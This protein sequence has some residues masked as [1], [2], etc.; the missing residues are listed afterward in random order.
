MKEILKKI[1]GF[2]NSKIFGYILIVIAIIFIFNL[3]GSKQNLKDEINRTNRNIEVLNATVKNE[4]LK[5]GEM[6]SSIA[7]YEGHAKEL[8]QYNK[9]L[10]DEVKSEKGKVVTYSNLVFRL[11]QDSTDLA[12]KLDS[13]RAVYEKPVKVNDST[14]NVDW[15]LPFVYD[16]VN[17]DIFTGRTQVSLGGGVPEAYLD[18][19][20]MHHN[21]TWLLNRD[22]QMKLTWGQKYEGDKLKVFART[23]HPAYQAQLMEGV[24][25]DYPS[26]KHWFTGFSV[27]PQFG[28]GYDFINSNTTLT[29]GVGIQ[30][31]IYTW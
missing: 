7:A 26:K 22:S 25:V 30:Y 3:W 2:M 20:V 12:N 4:R 5:N 8:E 14:W 21:K 29:V 11:R 15:I 10:A 9:E 28:I 27:G 31:N 1:W 13:L 6:Q 16:S 24:Y 23:N 17:Y 19:L 18:R